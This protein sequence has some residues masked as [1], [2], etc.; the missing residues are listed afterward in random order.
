M[1]E[2]ELSDL[3]EGE[4]WSGKKSIEYGLADSNRSYVDVLKA[5]FPNTKIEDLTRKTKRE[6]FIDFFQSLRAQQ[7]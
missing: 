4:I 6:K 7:L 1:S 2:T 5:E 3:R